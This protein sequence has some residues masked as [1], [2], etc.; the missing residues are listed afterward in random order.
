VANLHRA[1]NF[2]AE[3]VPQKYTFTFKGQNPTDLKADPFLGAKILQHAPD[4]IFREAERWP[5]P[6][7]FLLDVRG[8]PPACYDLFRAAESVSRAMQRYQNMLAGFATFQRDLGE[9]MQERSQ[10]G[11]V[12]GA[13]QLAEKLSREMVKH[14][15]W[16]DDSPRAIEDEPSRELQS[17]KAKAEQALVKRHGRKNLSIPKAKDFAWTSDWA[18]AGYLMVSNWLRWGKRGEPGLC[19]YG[20]QALADLLAILIRVKHSPPER[21]VRR[22]YFRK[23]RQLLGL[24][25]AYYRKPFV[26][27]ARRVLNSN[28]IEIECRWDE[29][30]Q[31]HLLAADQK[32]VIGT[33]QFYPIPS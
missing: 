33:R 15:L 18:L 6:W 23:C 30:T 4:F 3:S 28:Q 10:K 25:Q 32:M 22:D 19:Y 9:E 20:D 7:R 12:K 27:G 21:F 11:D 13:T 16:Q 24:E 8:L 31:K 2:Q 14:G 5:H 26:I 29:A 1:T 17:L